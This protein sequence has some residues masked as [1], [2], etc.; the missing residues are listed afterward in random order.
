MGS[1]ASVDTEVPKL[2][3]VNL[4]ERLEYRSEVLERFW[5]V[6]VNEY[7][8]SLPPYKGPQVKDSMG[9]GSVV[10][11][12]DDSCKLLKWPLGVIQKTFPGRDGLVRTVEV[13]T[14]GVILVRPIQ[15]IHLLEFS[16]TTQE[17]TLPN[18]ILNAQHMSTV[19]TETEC[20]ASRY[21]RVIKPKVKL[22]L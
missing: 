1:K 8:R 7:L 14:A 6:W 20:K 11:V 22:D 21:G 5:S 16:D 19:E 2:N 10:L 13:G 12:R 18:D 17:D 9:K 15:R 4:V 3:S